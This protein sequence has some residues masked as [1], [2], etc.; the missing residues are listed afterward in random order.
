MF[1]G[2]T[3]FKKHNTHVR[4]PQISNSKYLE[5]MYSFSRK[6]YIKLV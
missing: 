5:D 1:I 4:L 3:Q 6:A 2:Y